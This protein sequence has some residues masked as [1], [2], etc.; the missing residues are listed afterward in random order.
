MSRVTMVFGGSPPHCPGALRWRPTIMCACSLQLA[1]GV[2]RLAAFSP[3]ARPRSRRS[4]RLHRA[5]RTARCLG[6]HRRGRVPHRAAAADPGP[7]PEADPCGVALRQRRLLATCDSASRQRSHRAR[8]A[9]RRP[10]RAHRRLCPGPCPASPAS[11]CRLRSALNNLGNA[12][13]GAVQRV[14]QALLTHACEMGF[15]ARPSTYRIGVAPTSHARCRRC[16][17]W[18]A[19]GAT[20]IVITA[21]V[22]PGRVTVLSRCCCCIDARFAAAVLGVYR[23]ADRVPR[24]PGLADAELARV[25]ARLSC[26]GGATD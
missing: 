2:H 20:R 11:A 4:V 1:D 19:K 21:F 14:L 9:G 17:Q 13:P 24:E 22:L 16:K 10:R 26:A 3:S 5:A 8:H 15:K 12:P 18:I 7:A 25:C 23:T 6:S